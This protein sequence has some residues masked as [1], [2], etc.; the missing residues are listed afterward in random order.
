MAVHGFDWPMTLA[1]FVEHA[2]ENTHFKTRLESRG[3][4]NAVDWLRRS[5]EKATQTI[6]EQYLSPARLDLQHLI[7]RLSQHSLRDDERGFQK[8]LLLVAAKIGYDAN[9]L[10]PAI[11][12]RRW[13]AAAGISEKTVTRYVH[14][15]V[16]KGYLRPVPSETDSQ[17]TVYE[18]VTGLFGP[19]LTLEGAPGAGTPINPLPPGGTSGVP[20]PGKNQ[21]VVASLYHD[22]FRYKALGKLGFKVWLELQE[23]PD[24]IEPL[25]LK[26]IEQGT[27]NSSVYKILKRMEKGLMIHRERGRVCIRADADLDRAA[28][29]LNVAGTGARQ[30]ARHALERKAYQARVRETKERSAGLFD[31]VGSD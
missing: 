11:S 15:L 4:D 19:L 20:A 13:A 3:H 9:T 2:H 28:Q 30:K 21:I 18:I 10:Q 27:C 29:L 1:A 16:E 31:E 26:T 25:K 23:H 24:G 14:R 8:A 6:R 22:V 17:A 5:F 12:R 7:D